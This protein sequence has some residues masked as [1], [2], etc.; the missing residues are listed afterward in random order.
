MK[1]LFSVIFRQDIMT[2]GCYPWNSKNEPSKSNQHL[3][4]TC[5]ITAKSHIKVMR[6][7]DLITPLIDTQILLVSTTGNVRRTV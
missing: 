1:L 2:Q 5:S 3:I 6:T 7:K 4:S